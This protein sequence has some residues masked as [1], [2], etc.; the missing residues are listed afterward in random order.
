MFG[1]SA[2]SRAAV[3][4]PIPRMDVRRFLFSRS[5]RFCFKRSRISRSMFLVCRSR[6][7]RCWRMPDSTALDRPG[8]CSR[9]RSLAHIH[10]A[11]KTAHKPLHIF[12]S[13][14]RPASWPLRSTEAC[15]QRGM[16]CVIFWPLALPTR[17]RP[18]RIYHGDLVITVA[19]MICKSLPVGVRCFQ[20]STYAGGFSILQRGVELREALH[21]ICKVLRQRLLVIAKKNGVERGRRDVYPENRFQ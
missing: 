16:H 7:P 6:Y 15:E 2:S 8:T 17:V 3:M 4:S 13:R 19:Q 1:I 11:R 12:L 10:H 21:R 14:R 20:A 9:L 5:R 18:A